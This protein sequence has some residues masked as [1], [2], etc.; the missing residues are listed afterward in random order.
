MTIANI[1]VATDFSDGAD[2]AVATALTWAGPLAASVHLFHVVEYGFAAG[3][4]AS[5]I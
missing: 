4:W 3:R 1:L 2:A 5:E